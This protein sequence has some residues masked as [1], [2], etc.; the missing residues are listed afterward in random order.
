MQLVDDRS[1][2]LPPGPLAVAPLVR[3][4]V[5]GA[6]PLVD[7]VRLASRARVGADVGAVDG[8]AVVDLAQRLAA[9]DPAL[10]DA[11]GMTPAAS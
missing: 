3:R 9:R 7:T 1:G 10:A 6:R 5:E 11:Y 4:G 8:V 2:E